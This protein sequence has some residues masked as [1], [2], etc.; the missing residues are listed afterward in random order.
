M[1]LEPIKTGRSS[2]ATELIQGELRDSN[3]F[4]PREFI[5][6]K[7]RDY[8]EQLI[9]QPTLTQAELDAL[10][11]SWW[12][13]GLDEQYT[14][15]LA[16]AP[17]LEDFIWSEILRFREM[18]LHPF[19]EQKKVSDLSP[20]EAIQ[21]LI[22]YFDV[23]KLLSIFPNSS[24]SEHALKLFEEE[25]NVFLELLDQP[26]LPTHQ[27]LQIIF[28]LSHFLPAQKTEL[29]KKISMDTVKQELE[30]SQELDS[31]II[32]LALFPELRPQVET[33]FEQ[34][35]SKAE[36]SIRELKKNRFQSPTGFG[37]YLYEAFPYMALTAAD[38]SLR[39]NGTLNIRLQPKLSKATPPLPQRPNI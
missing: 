18:N 23:A 35:R 20:E 36:K 32:I 17:G 37:N 5:H 15:R 16:Q 11:T 28:T 3:E 34:L 1:R 12:I 31:L 24:H 8:L 6:G 38:L 21:V 4:D 39:A 10:T 14:E 13:S 30:S 7:D 25:K 29:K 22:T 33:V 2:K 9:H 26:E 19:D 27:K